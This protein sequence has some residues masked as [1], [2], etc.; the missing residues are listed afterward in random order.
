MYSVKRE[1]D[2]VTITM[3]DSEF[4]PSSTGEVG[5][6]GQIVYRANKRDFI[7]VGDLGVKEVGEVSDKLLIQTLHQKGIL[8]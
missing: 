3:A 8:R 2:Q 7:V 1:G 6:S 4:Q 5:Q